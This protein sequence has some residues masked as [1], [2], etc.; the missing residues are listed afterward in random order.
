MW[1]T[2]CRW[3]ALAWG[4]ASCT[5]SNQDAAEAN[6]VDGSAVTPEIDGSTSA[7]DPAAEDDVTSSSGD[8]SSRPTSTDEGAEQSAPA[9]T[10]DDEG[11]EADDAV[12]SNSMGADPGQRTDDDAAAVDDGSVGG[13]QTDDAPGTGSAD[14]GATADTDPS[15]QDGD[16][17]MAD[18]AEA[19]DDTPV[20]RGVTIDGVQ[21]RVDG[22]PF[23]VRGVCWNPVPAGADHP[24]GLDFSGYVGI[25]APL[26]AEAGINAVRT[27]E[28]IL[29]VNVLD[30]LYEHGIYV[31]NSIYPWGGD[32]PSVVTERV[33]ATKG[34]PA[35]IMWALGNEW[36]YNGLY[37]DMP[38]EDA[39]A[40]I[41]EAAALV[42]SA[43]PSRP[44]TTIYGELPA[45]DVISAMPDIDVWGINTYRGISFGQLFT[46]W[47][48]RSDKP[49]FISEYGADAF[50]ANIGAYDPDSQAE[51]VMAL[52]QEIADNASAFGEG[53]CMGGT[54]FE[55]ADEWWK[56]GAGSND[57]QD[58]GG[59]APGGGPHP[60][61]T[62]NEEW[63]GIV[64]IDRAPRPAYEALREVFSAQ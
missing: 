59:I 23:H 49:M 17:A 64:D 13:E 14:D 34:H 45:A 20:D 63:W 1:R 50:N 46:E 41:N 61:Q 30:G 19:S 36:N 62:F 8:S 47:E 11:A 7:D 37:V 35:V 48:A 10:L 6:G 56:D 18:D 2:Y 53:S 39:L 27:Y 60:D 42:A 24:A 54:L 12:D 38:H 28:P 25:D 57:V 5:S 43:D 58:Q 29:D 32:S 26:M 40:A 3:L 55:W 21:L 31:I 15:E 51:A 33:N 22:A 9:G 16:T 52:T 44:I 4:V